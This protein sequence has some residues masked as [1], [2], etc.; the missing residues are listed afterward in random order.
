MPAQWLE[1]GAS[2]VLVNATPE[3]VVAAWEKAVKAF[4]EQ[5]AG[6]PI[7]DKVAETLLGLKVVTPNWQT[8]YSTIRDGRAGSCPLLIRAAGSRVK[9]RLKLSVRPEDFP[10]DGWSFAIPDSDLEPGRNV[11]LNA[12]IT[13][14]EGKARMLSIPLYGELFGAGWKLVFTT[15]MADTWDAMTLDKFKVSQP[16][17][18]P[19]GKQSRIGYIKY[20]QIPKPPKDQLVDG[21]MESGRFAFASLYSGAGSEGKIMYGTT[22]L[23]AKSPV[24]VKFQFSDNSLFFVNGKIVGTTLSRGQ[25][26]FVHLEEGDNKVEMIMLPSKRDGWRFGLPRITWVEKAMVLE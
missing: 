15:T 19:L 25:W 5:N 22:T 2:T 4:A 21:P 3:Q 8:A 11:D 10:L 17:A 7:S 14:S 26:V 12:T 18:N 9:A 24:K 13:K 20:E 16:L 1:V 23:K 6:K